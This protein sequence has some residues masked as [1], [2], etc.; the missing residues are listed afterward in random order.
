MDQMEKNKEQKK[1][2]IRVQLSEKPL[3]QDPQPC[4][5]KDRTNLGKR[6]AAKKVI[7]SL[8]VGS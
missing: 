4:D 3:D 6:E 7:F 2:R 1:K 8:V 5:K